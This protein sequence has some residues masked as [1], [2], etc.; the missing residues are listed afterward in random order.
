MLASPC[1]PWAHTHQMRVGGLAEGRTRSGPAAKVGSFLCSNLEGLFRGLPRDG[2]ESSRQPMWLSLRSC[3]CRTSSG[4]LKEEQVG[5]FSLPLPQAS[6]PIDV[7][8][9]ATGSDPRG[10]GLVPFL[11]RAISIHGG[12]PESRSPHPKGVTLW[13]GPRETAQDEERNRKQGEHQRIVFVPSAAASG[14]EAFAKAFKGGLQGLP[15]ISI[16]N[17]SLASGIASRVFVP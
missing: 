16:F 14:K 15:Q 12:C 13:I 17:W 9:P 4:V 10:L 6:P 1:K 3:F 2:S 5:P 8:S 11:G 7:P